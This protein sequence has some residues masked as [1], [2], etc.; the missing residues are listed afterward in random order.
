MTRPGLEAGQSENVH[1]VPLLYID[2]LIYQRIWHGHTSAFF[3]TLP[4]TCITLDFCAC[5]DKI[6]SYCLFF[7]S[8][9]LLGRIYPI[10]LSCPC[11]CL[12]H[13]GNPSFWANISELYTAAICRRSAACCGEV[14]ACFVQINVGVVRGK[15]P[16]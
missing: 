8:V 10:P 7:N 2:L 11:R 15:C 3:L 6:R 16:L 4:L 9:F 1:F 13:S 14:T 5:L 12:C